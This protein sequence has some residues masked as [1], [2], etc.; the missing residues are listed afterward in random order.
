M[1]NLENLKND[2]NVYILGAGFSREAVLPIISDFL[3]T[4]RDS[5]EWL[6]EQNRIKEATAVAKVLRFRLDAASAAYWVNLDL[7]NIEELFSLASTNTDDI[8]QQISLAIAATL[9]YAKK[10]KGSLPGVLSISHGTGIFDPKRNSPNWLNVSTRDDLNNSSWYSIKTYS[11]I[12]AH[13]LGMLN[14]GNPKGENSF[15]TFNYDT[16]L[17]DALIDLRL[18]VTYGSKIG[19]H[20]SLDEQQAKPSIPIFK[21]HGS[22]NWARIEPTSSGN[23]H[24]LKAFKSYDELL[25]NKL[26]PELIPP[27]WKKIFENQLQAVWEEAIQKLQTATRIIVIGFSMPPKDLHFKYLLAAGLKDNISLRNVM[28]VNPDEKQEL[29]PRVRD[30]LRE[31][32][33]ESNQIS[34]QKIGLSGFTISRLGQG[35]PQI[36]NSIGRP[37][38]SGGNFYFQNNQ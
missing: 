3:L 28:F 37:V 10:K 12:T 17:E 1:S 29:E 21:L 36:L 23:S 25:E 27:T 34:F 16:L 30:L 9:D 13:L 31:D 19:A 18:P 11:L 20:P 4:M 15:I 5:H 22:V 35:N 14:D 38:T 6:L 2:H 24:S 7:E 33:I 32:Y 26:T 8:S